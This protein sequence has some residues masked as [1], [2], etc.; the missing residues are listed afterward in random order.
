MDAPDKHED[1]DVP[2]PALT[3]A[4]RY[5]FEVNGYVLLKNTLDAEEVGTLKEVLYRIRRGIIAK[6][7]VR[8]ITKGVANDQY[9]G[10]A[11]FPDADPAV[12]AYMVHPLFLGAAREVCG[13]SVRLNSAN[14]SIRLPASAGQQKDKW[15][16]HLG[17]RPEWGSFQRNGLFHTT[18]ARTLTYLTDITP[19]E[20]TA[21]IAGSHKLSEEVSQ[22]DII[23]A[24]MEDPSL[25]HRVTARAGDTVLFAESLIHSAPAEFTARER[26]MI[27]SVY[28]QPMY[29]PWMGYEIT[30]Q[31]L[32]DIDPR[33]HAFITGGDMWHWKQKARPALGTAAQ[34]VEKIELAISR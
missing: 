2:F 31:M 33:Y 4:Q 24:A 34:K 30:P 6:E 5:H 22:E 18:M 3:P 27:T 25:I 29:Q 21:F 14:A 23:A 11:L 9:A 7:P 8:G 13:G 1:L 10:C 16:F 28:T 19:E 17:V 32:E 26:I 12:F 15:A 20:S